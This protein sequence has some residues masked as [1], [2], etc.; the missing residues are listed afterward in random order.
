MSK[1]QF[2]VI[3]DN[4]DDD[5]KRPSESKGVNTDKRSVSTNVVPITPTTMKVH[6]PE[7]PTDSRSFDFAPYYGQGFDAITTIC[8]ATIEKRIQQSIDTQQA[9]I[10]VSTIAG[11]C[12][13]GLKSF[14]G[15]LTLWRAGAK[16]DLQPVDIT[17]ELIKEYIHHRMTRK[18]QVV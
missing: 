18:D 4:Q 17:P 7:N 8:Q 1:K 2:N 6:F 3:T 10:A 13:I 11:Y 14:F 16:R 9:A 15:F 12:S 5:T